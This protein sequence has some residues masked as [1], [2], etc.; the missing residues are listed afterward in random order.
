MFKIVI[1][2]FGMAFFVMF[3][4]SLAASG[5]TVQINPDVAIGPT[6]IRAGWD[7]KGFANQIDTIPEARR[8]YLDVDANFLRI[9][10]N[11]NAHNEDGTVEIS[12]YEV[13]LNAINSVLAVRPEVEIYASVRLLGAGTF[14][15]WVSQPSAAWP[16]ETGMIFNNTVARPN[17][18]LYARMVMDYLSFMREQGISID[19]L[20]LNNETDGAV[21]PDRYVATHDLLEAR[22]DAAGFPSEYRDFQYVG[23]DT[24]GLPGAEGFIEAIADAGRLDAIDIIASHYYPQFISGNE[25][26]W[27]DLSDLSGG[28]PLF[29]SELHMP[30]NEPAIAEIS[31]TVRD[32]LSI[33]FAS[34][35]NGVDS[36][37]WWD[38][39]NNTDEVR[40][41]VKREVMTTTLGAAPVLTTPTYQ[42]RGDSDGEPLF[43]AFVEGSQVTLWISNPGSE[44]NNLSVN[45]LSQQVGSCLDGRQYLAP[46]GDNDL[47][48]ADISPLN[49][50]L[51]EN[52]QSFT[53]EQIP[54]Q[55]VAIVTF[56][57]DAQTPAS[58][59]TDV[60]FS[61]DFE[62]GNMAAET[63]S[64]TLVADSATPSIV[65]VTGGADA[66]LGSNV[67]LLDQ[68][69]TTLDLTLNLTD[70]LSLE[71]GNTVTLDF[72]VSA[73]RTNGNSRTVYV[74]ALDSTGKTVAR[75][76]L[77][78]SNI[79][80]NGAADRQRPGYA[81]GAFGNVPFR[82]GDDFWWG[83]DTS[84]DG[85]NAGTDAHMSLT[86]REFCFEFSTTSQNGR[87]FSTSGLTNFAGSSADITEIRMTS[88][89]AV[90]GIYLDNISVAGVIAD[91]VG[92]LVGDFEPD[93]DVDID[94]I[95][96]YVGNIGAAAVGS[97]AQQDFDGDGFV[98]LN[99]RQIHIE[100]YVQTSN[101]QTGT[102]LGDLNLDGTVSVLGDAFLLIGNL[103]SAVSSYADGD[104]N[105]DGIVDVLGDAFVLIGNLN[106]SNDP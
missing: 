87:T 89:G 17:P 16:A 66:T 70:T 96:F 74:D 22:L 83:A 61:N 48:R 31:Q 50:T 64:M 33:Q 98:T 12:Q 23:P 53:I 78:D 100:T 58:T 14:P 32:S 43:Q 47:L 106:S 63:G 67:L 27:Q 5:Q 57:M 84:P 94:D 75:L 69:M 30:S 29:H 13:A 2:R 8:H 91:S 101:G 15:A 102:F 20:G 49:F 95:D 24:F 4:T 7:I 62:D 73:R 35:R 68:N 76:V 42:D 90:Y 28:L 105:F 34:F 46:D 56:D 81:G 103:G 19:F 93:G 97:L 18:E 44:I 52:G 45:M 10:F 40:D 9:P 65:P 104:V 39:G 36:Y 55:S 38:S 54:S 82:G 1:R 26:D 41:V 25:S 92:G 85:F 86:I 59:N 99:D 51:S 71:D 80:G 79:F 6:I 37:I 77:G 88:L 72:D 3:L 60:V 11:P 21:P